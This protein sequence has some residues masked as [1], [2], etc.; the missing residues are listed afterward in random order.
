MTQDTVGHL[1]VKIVVRG[2]KRKKRTS[3]MV[4][5]YT[6]ATNPRV[7]GGFYSLAKPA[8]GG[9]IW[10]EKRARTYG[11]NIWREKRAGTYDGNKEREHMAVKIWRG[12]M[13]RNMA[14][15]MRGK[16]CTSFN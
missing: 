12:Q 11:G 8:I 1:W 7:R 2:I 14:E 5:C 4:G 16:I 10:R 3:N 9:N 13:V 6:D 15:K